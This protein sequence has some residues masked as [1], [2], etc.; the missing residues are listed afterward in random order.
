MARRKISQSPATEST[1]APT[2]LHQKLST[3]QE[4]R[5]WLLRQ[6]RRK[7]TELN[8]FMA[9]MQDV[10]RELFHQGA[11]LFNQL[12]DIDTEIH[13]LFEELLTKRKM[14]QQSRQKVRSLYQSLQLQGTIS[15]Q[16]LSGF[17]ESNDFFADVAGETPTD[18]SPFEPEESGFGFPDSRG[19][20]AE[21]PPQSPTS[22][23]ASSPQDRT[24]R[25]TFLRLAAIY[26]PDR[27]QDEDTQ[28]QNT[29][30]M[31]AINKA[32][33]SG[34]FALLLELEQ[35]QN[36]G[37]ATLDVSALGDDLEQQCQQL[38]K[39]NSGLREQYEGI[40]A[41]LRE[42]RNNTQEGMMVTTYRKA[43]K[44]G[45]DFTDELLQETAGEVAYL[46]KIRDFVR[47]FRDRKITLKAFLAG[48]QPDSPEDLMA[49]MEQMFGISIHMYPGGFP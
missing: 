37:D 29:E 47:D 8:N 33:K 7:R 15:F 16:P 27:A 10:V 39:E 6:I 5:Q 18:G 1:L 35:Q 42:L 23:S 44:E 31:K 46:E 25:Q 24:F 17:A 20:N 40:K 32:Y 22:E 9:Q 41:E 38:A 26:H 3:L 19:T 12:R 48:P 28:Q 11:D 30:V 13:A 49:M 34:D 36:Q 43:A 21:V 2:A 45:I 14:G 4:E